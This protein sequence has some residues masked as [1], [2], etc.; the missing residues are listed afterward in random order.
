M[1]LYHKF[2]IALFAMAAASLVS[3]FVL[4]INFQKREILKSEKEKI[5]FV[6]KGIRNIISEG[7]LSKDPLM[8][9]DYLSALGKN[10]PEISAIQLFAQGRWHIIKKKKSN[11]ESNLIE[12][13][14]AMRPYSVKLLFSG[15]YFENRRKK[16]L[17]EILTNALVAAFISL[18]LSLVIALA[19]SAN[20]RKRLK[21]LAG[22]SKKISAN[23]F[24]H[25]VEIKGNDE[26]SELGSNFNMMSEKL[27]ELEDMKRMFVSSVTHELKSPLGI[28]SNYL[29]ILA[30]TETGISTENRRNIAQIKENISRLSNFINALLSVSR[31]EKGKFEMHPSRCDIARVLRD[32]ASF[33][34]EKARAKGIELSV[35]APEKLTIY[36]DGE[37]I[38]HVITNFV[39]NSLKFTQSG[40]QIII[41]AER[42]KKNLLE[43]A[44]KDT[45][46]GIKPQ[47]QKKIFTA[48]AQI[49]NPENKKGTGLGLYLSKKII[50]AHKGRIGFSSR[51]GEGSRFWI[52]IPCCL[53]E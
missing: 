1:K 25:K 32:I 34:R 52:S 15:K 28:I 10:R 18:L 8:I 50:E 35:E 24:G 22:F 14:I 5:L 4:F 53:R 37:M 46:I 47:E 2:N 12:R 31:I 19:L 42:K 9:A 43:I 23:E 40:G 3:S 41:S 48:F 21:I 6:E 30:K 44:V 36:A 49:K 11:A 13:K 38:S 26:I 51:P 29:D 39:S 7:I 20:M 27:V 33:F 45:G 17:G 16:L